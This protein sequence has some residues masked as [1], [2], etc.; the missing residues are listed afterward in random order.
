MENKLRAY[1]EELFSEVT[2]TKQAVELK[3]E[4]LQNLMDKYHDLLAEGKSPEAAYNIA[5][6]SIGDTDELL[7]TLKQGTQ[8]FSQE[9]L[10]NRRKKSAILISISVMLYILSVI[11]VILFEQ[12]G[13]EI[14][15]V[16]LMF[17]MVAIAT[18]LI[19]YNA[20]TKP[21]YLKKDD[22]MV[23]EFKEWK[24]N[25]YSPN[26]SVM[27]A[28]NSAIWS[29]TV[30]IYMIISFTTF[31]WHITWVLFLIAAAVQGVVKA[32]FELRG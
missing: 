20:M 29:I 30:V 14:I 9:Q 32:V 25:Q 23:E 31:A 15:G 27:K 24:T 5:V 7:S 10:E 21:K 1:M 2:P 8:T 11:P 4:I 17:I 28:I 22:S 13:Y 3:E 18:G 12:F 26:R 16:S 6:S 19:I